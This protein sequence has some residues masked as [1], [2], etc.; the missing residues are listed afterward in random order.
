MHKILL[1]RKFGLASYAAAQGIAGS[2]AEG[3]SGTH[4]QSVATAT[5]G[6]LRTGSILFVF[7]H[8][9]SNPLSNT[10]IY[11]ACLVYFVSFSCL[12]YYMKAIITLG[13]WSVQYLECSL[14]TVINSILMQSTDNSI[15][16][17]VYSHPG[18]IKLYEHCSFK[19]QIYLVT[20]KEL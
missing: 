10:L 14:H 8:S 20:R 17:I 9:S 6:Y 19:L 3:A 4:G 7:N 11:P 5:A 18:L 15:L 16:N 1:M 13:S 2:C 12:Y